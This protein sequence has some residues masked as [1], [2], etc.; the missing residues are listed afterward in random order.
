MPHQASTLAT[1]PPLCP[2]G[3][4]FD[5]EEGDGLAAPAGAAEPIEPCAARLSGSVHSGMGRGALYLGAK[6]GPLLRP[7]YD[8]GWK[9]TLVGHSLGAG[10]WVGGC[11]A[12][13]VDGRLFVARLLPPPPPLPPPPLPLLPLPHL[14]PSLQPPP[15]PHPP[16]PPHTHTTPPQ[17]WPPCW[18]CTCATGGWAPTAWP[19]G[20]TKRRPAWM[21][22]WRR[23]AQVGQTKGKRVFFSSLPGMRT[24]AWARPPFPSSYTP[25]PLPALHTLLPPVLFSSSPQTP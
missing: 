4:A 17:A 1:T 15:P 12:V 23:R 2:A 10:G 20:P 16:H 11:I 18:L 14:T 24:F 3:E 19:A 9:V 25:A 6:F 21:W 8:Q 5:A 13:G 22:G 7:L